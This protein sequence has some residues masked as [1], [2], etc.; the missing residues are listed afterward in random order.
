MRIID[1]TPRTTNG[2]TGRY[3]TTPGQLIGI[4]VHHTVSPQPS[5]NSDAT[6][7]NHA[8]MIDVYHASLG[9]GGI[10]YHALAFPSGA[11]YLTGV[12]GGA[13]AHVASRNHQ[14]LGIA[15]V[16]DY[17]AG[18][19]SPALIHA[20]QQ[21]INA[22]NT[23]AGQPLPIAGHRAWALPQ[24]PTACPGAQHAGWLPLLQSDAD[25]DEPRIRQ[26]FAEE[27]ARAH[28]QPSAAPVHTV[29]REGE[30]GLWGIWE[31]RG[32]PQP[33]ERWLPTTLLLNG[34][35]TPPVLHIGQ[36]IAVAA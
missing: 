8:L 11:A 5:F 35:P 34:W 10:G 27:H 24:F 21:L 3:Q 26:I 31:H 7:I 36:Q 32:K 17:T 33:W 6:E 12:W 15:A 18:P 2:T 28:H 25:M 22:A 19:P 9:Y 13:R 4:A 14:L 1:L 16:G 29:G 20:L 30:R 23:H